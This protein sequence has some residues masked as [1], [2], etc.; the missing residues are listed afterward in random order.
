MS[1]RIHCVKMDTRGYVAIKDC[2]HQ[3]FCF[4][5]SHKLVDPR[6]GDYLYIEELDYNY[7]LSVTTETGWSL[8]RR[9]D[10]LDNKRWM[11]LSCP[12]SA[13]CD[14]L[15]ALLDASKAVTA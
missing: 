8:F 3:E 1:D 15:R 12:N 9:I 10:T 4:G 13:D 7:D 14:R 5:F 11:R 6:V 2:V